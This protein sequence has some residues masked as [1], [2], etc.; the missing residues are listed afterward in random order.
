MPKPPSKNPL[1]HLRASDL[2]GMAQLATQATLGVARMVEGV[3]QSVWR[4]LG[5]PG[6]PAPGQTRGITGL[7]YKS[8]RGVT[9]LVGGGV[10]ALLAQLQ[11]VLEPADNAQASAPQREAV[12]AALNGVLGDHLLASHS[13]FA[14]P[15]TLRFNGE[16]LNPQALPAM[17]HAS[18]KVLLLIHG[19]CMNDL[20]WHAQHQGQAVNHGAAVASALGYTPVYLR[21]N[22]GLHTS[23]NGHELAALLAELITH[24][25]VPVQE[26]SV[27]AHS[28]GG[29]LIRS[30][31][32]DAQAQNLGWPNHLKNIVFLGTPHHGAPLERAGNWADVILASTPYSAPFAKLGHLRSAGITDLRYGHVLDVDW[33]GHDRF[34]RKPDSRQLL[35][36]P[37]GVACY[38]IAAALAPKRSALADRLIGDGLVPL[39][40]AL[41]QHD[42][43][44]RS[45]AFASTSQWICY[46][47][48]HIALLSS[49]EVT[50]QIVAW[51][52][53][54]PGQTAAGWATSRMIDDTSRPTP[55]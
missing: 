40:S 13:P 43:P 1:K 41:G 8:V 36:L 11:P 16:V 10:D 33:Q 47:T 37:A 51:L 39:R 19:L 38:A 53:P 22:S 15:M 44:Q 54:Q 30:A 55:R 20:Q 48:S 23:Q 4:T 28:M 3:H 29:L 14:I 5:A 2:R 31:V 52:T 34:R 6:G 18:G 42:N 32:Y 46:R 35:P 24:W 17:P 50:R 12:L 45:L 26:L 9:R 7:V 25:P 27:V 49:P 21:Y